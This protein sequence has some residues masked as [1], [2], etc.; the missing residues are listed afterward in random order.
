M[1]R[2]ATLLVLLISLF[3]QSSYSQNCQRTGLCKLAIPGDFDLNK[4]LLLKEN[5]NDFAAVDLE[6]EFPIF[7]NQVLNVASIRLDALGCIYPSFIN[8]G[9]YRNEFLDEQRSQTKYNKLSFYRVFEQQP[10][11]LNAHLSTS[12]IDSLKSISFHH[13]SL[14]AARYYAFRAFWNRKFLGDKITELDKKIAERKIKRVF[15][16]VHGFNVPS[17]LAQLQGNAIFRRILQDQSLRPE[18]TL[19]VRVFWPSMSEKR[20]DFVN[21]DKCDIRNRKL[22][23]FKSNLF[24]YV[25]NRGYLCGQTLNTILSQLPNDIEYNFISHSFGS[26]LSA[27]MLFSP[28]AKINVNARGSHY[29]SRLLAL[30]SNQPKLSEKKINFFM[31]AAGMAGRATFADLSLANNTNHYFYLGYNERDKILLKQ[32]LWLFKKPHGKSSTA[33]G[34]NADGEADKVVALAD[35]TGL[36]SRFVASSTSTLREHDIFCY[37]QQ[38]QFDNFFTTFLQR[39][40]N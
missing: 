1:L 30:F 31:H 3:Q 13:D 6:N 26:T 11:L 5:W 2:P 28:T 15:F 16:F 39:T 19:F 25:S 40:S 12:E 21:V 22:R 24:S 37:M 18:E 20:N 27:A 9:T 33:L 7:S 36:L 34:C 14:Y 35:R 10:N 23:V 8:N 29:N 38:T 4:R 17:S 32:V